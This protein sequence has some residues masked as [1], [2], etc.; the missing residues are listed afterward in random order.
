MGGVGGLG[1]QVRFSVPAG[2]RGVGEERGEAED[3]IT[4]VGQRRGKG[5][6]RGRVI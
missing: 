4:R 3:E 6:R 2:L 1:G 5:R